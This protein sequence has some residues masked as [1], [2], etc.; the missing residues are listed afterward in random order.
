MATDN[1]T[2]TNGTL[3]NTHDSLWDTASGGD[4]DNGEINNNDLQPAG[5]WT[6]CAAFYN[7]SQPADQESE[8]GFKAT[9]AFR[10]NRRAGVRKSST[11]QGYEI[12]FSVGSGGNYTTLEMAKDG[13]WFATLASSGSWAYNIVH[14]AKIKVYGTSTTSIEGWVD[15]TQIGSTQTDATSPITTG[16]PGL[17]IEGDG[18][19]EHTVTY[20]TDNITAGGGAKFPTPHLWWSEA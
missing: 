20:W 17:R 7:N 3:L 4:V 19:R 11:N 9:T 14:V 10:F 8:L 5:D 16:N 12:Y 2:D 13:S 6:V 15:G 1:F 18:T